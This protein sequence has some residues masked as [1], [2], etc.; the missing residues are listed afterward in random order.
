MSDQLP[1][2]T[3]NMH[4]RT[5]KNSTTIMFSDGNNLHQKNLKAMMLKLPAKVAQQL[6]SDYSH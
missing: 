5:K 4:V 1:L 3:P 2:S 6:P